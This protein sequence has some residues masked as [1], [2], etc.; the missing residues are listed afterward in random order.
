MIQSLNLVLNTLLSFSFTFFFSERNR[1]EAVVN[2]HFCIMV[3]IVLSDNHFISI[4]Y[5]FWT[6]KSIR[7]AIVIDHVFFLLFLHRVLA[8]SYLESSRFLRFSLNDLRF[9]NRVTTNNDLIE[10]SYKEMAWKKPELTRAVWWC[11]FDEYT[12]IY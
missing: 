11:H 2:L 12:C 3:P 9:H 6:L 8:E 4:H 7:F 5:F 1:N 10:L